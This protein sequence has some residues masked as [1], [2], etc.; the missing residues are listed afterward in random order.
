VHF[1]QESKKLSLFGRCKKKTKT[2]KNKKKKKKNKKKKKTKQKTKK[3]KKKK[4]KKKTKQ[5]KT[6]FKTENSGLEKYLMTNANEVG[7]KFAIP[8]IFLISF[9]L[10]VLMLDFKVD[11]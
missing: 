6:K 7:Q 4:K 9:L 2:K 1:A 5:N 11:L 10:I 8:W 3:N